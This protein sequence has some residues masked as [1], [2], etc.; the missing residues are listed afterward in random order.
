MTS[1]RRAH[2]AGE[3]GRLLRF[4]LAPRLEPRSGPSRLYRSGKVLRPFAELP[5]LLCNFL[6][7]D[8][9]SIRLAHYEAK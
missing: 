8:R 3:G 6:G 1:P 4:T 5:S 9:V 2:Q 7:Y